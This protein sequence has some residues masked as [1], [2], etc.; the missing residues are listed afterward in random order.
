MDEARADR[1]VA[2]ILVD[3]YGLN[4]E[5][6]RRGPDQR[7]QTVIA[8]DA[9]ARTW[10][11]PFVMAGIN[12]KVVR[13]S[14]ALSA[15]AYGKDFRYREA[16]MTGPGPAGW[17][18]AAAMTAGLGAFMFANSHSLSRSLLVSRLVPKP[19]E[20]PSRTERNNGFFRLMFFGTLADGKVMRAT[21]TG[22]RDPGYGSTS[23]MLSESAVC[24]A[25]N[26]LP[27]GGGFWTPVSAMGEALFRRLTGKAGITFELH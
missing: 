23:K 24:L 7:D 2:R 20:G 26:S 15:Y 16:V 6:E 21:V 13:R 22:D 18:K 3:P 17:S 12:T 4:P 9:T 1:N 5:G 25:V 10:T 27:V 14:N 19:G 11:A 8:Y